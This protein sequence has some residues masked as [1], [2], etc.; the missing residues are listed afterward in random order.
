MDAVCVLK[1]LSLSSYSLASLWLR[2]VICIKEGGFQMSVVLWYC[3][4][5]IG[6]STLW[7]SNNLWPESSNLSSYFLIMPCLYDMYFITFVWKK[8]RTGPLTDSW[9]KDLILANVLH[10]SCVK[11][12]LCFLTHMHTH[13]H[14]HTEACT[15]SHAHTHARTTA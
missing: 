8:N 7:H 2:S 15:H 12:V 13:T 9:L 11:L 10:D 1:L 4:Y 3:L 5:S 6:K 14:M